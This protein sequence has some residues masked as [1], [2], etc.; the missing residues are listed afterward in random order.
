[1]TAIQ[2][3]SLSHSGLF[4]PENLMLCVSRAW[5]RA[6]ISLQLSFF[7]SERCPQKP[8]E[9][10]LSPQKQLSF[11]CLLLRSGLWRKVL[12]CLLRSSRVY[13]AV[14]RDPDGPATPEPPEEGVSPKPAWGPFQ[15]Q[16]R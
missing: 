1:M 9:K 4:W 16:S 10:T 8:H 15:V 5:E 7:L 3:Y 13:Q 14:P 12:A 2:V 11:F 6:V